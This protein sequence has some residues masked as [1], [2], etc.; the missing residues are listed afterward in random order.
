MAWLLRLVRP[1]GLWPLRPLRPLRLSP[2][3]RFIGLLRLLG[4]VRLGC[5]PRRL[6]VAWLLRL[7]RP[8]GLWPLR[9]FPLFRFIGLLRLLGA[10]RLLC[11]LRRS[12][13][14]R[15]LWRLSVPRLPCR[16]WLLCLAFR[17]LR[18]L[19]LA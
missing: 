17:L 18:L 8:L 7:V 1:L 9:L 16:I 19:Q 10:V 6:G 15:L 14:A 13:V 5:L 2:L 12:R 11:L 4:A 3:F